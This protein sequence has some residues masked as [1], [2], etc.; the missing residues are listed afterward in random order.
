MPK[1]ES[2]ATRLQRHAYKILKT[3]KLDAIDAQQ[4]IAGRH[5]STHWR[6]LEAAERATEII[7]E[8]NERIMGLSR[9]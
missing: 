6:V 8:R 3:T 9:R 5:W 1:S 4:K 2:S 7:V